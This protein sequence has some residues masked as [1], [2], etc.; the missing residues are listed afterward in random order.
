[1]LTRKPDGHLD[2]W[3]LAQLIEV[4]GQLAVLKE[5][6]LV[7]ARQSKDFRNLIH[8]GKAKRLK[9][10]CDRSTALVAVAAL[11]RVITELKKK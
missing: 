4:A 8:P 10:E 3:G 5:D 2:N 1:M 9:Q 6:T 7:T 11:E